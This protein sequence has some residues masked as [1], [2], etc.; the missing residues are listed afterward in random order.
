MTQP[1]PTFWWRIR[2]SCVTVTRSCLALFTLHTSAILR[3]HLFDIVTCSHS[4][5]TLLVLLFYKCSLVP[6]CNLVS[7]SYLNWK[8]AQHWCS[9]CCPVTL[10]AE[11]MVFFE[12]L[13]FITG[14]CIPLLIFLIYLR[15][16]RG[17]FSL[18][19]TEGRTT[20]NSTATRFSQARSHQEIPVSIKKF[21]GDPESF[22]EW[23]FAVELAIRS[24]NLREG[25]LQVDFVS[26]LL[27]GDA[28]LWL[29][30]AQDS[31]ETFE[32]WP[33]LKNALAKTF[34]PLQSE[35]ENR[36]QL[37]S[38]QQETTLESYIQDF[39][40]RNLNVSGLDE[41][42]RALL[43][44]RGLQPEL[45]SEALREHPRNLSD[46][47]RAARSAVRQT[48]A[49]PR[50]APGAQDNAFHRPRPRQRN[51]KS[52]SVRGGG[53]LFRKKLDEQM[54]VQLMREGKCFRCRLT[55]HL[56]KDC[57]ENEHPNSDRQ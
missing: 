43:F 36:L 55:G 32:D 44:V 20:A 3:F 37:F 45:R 38:L 41:H 54:R 23:A 30:A 48:Q 57:P 53:S 25:S 14:A 29:I 17:I 46:A 11:R 7:F 6:I 50:V 51:Q 47:F 34:G 1:T 9:D 18:L 21:N 33:S 40:R 16:I 56:A 27:E 31:G 2:V 35:E 26:M 28:L 39:S 52:T 4:F 8:P 49:D 12:L 24:R 5:H 42:S 13:V 15:D 19:N 10:V 22:R